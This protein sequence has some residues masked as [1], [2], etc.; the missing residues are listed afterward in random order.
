MPKSRKNYPKIEAKVWNCGLIM[1]RSRSRRIGRTP[2]PT[3][4]TRAGPDMSRAQCKTYMGPYTQLVLEV[5]LD[6]SI[7]TYI[8]NTILSKL[9]TRNI[10]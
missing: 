5:S 7:A 1:S 9:L 2:S 6:I 8:S 4:L 10:R 3:G